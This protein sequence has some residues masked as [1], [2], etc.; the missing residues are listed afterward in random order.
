M[1]NEKLSLRKLAEECNISY[2]T[3]SR[4]MNGQGHKHKLATVKLVESTA[5]KLGYRRNLLA[6]GMM[7]GQSLAIGVV[8][9]Y[10]SSREFNSE[11]LEGIQ[12]E[13]EQH[14]YVAINLTVNGSKEDVARAHQLIERRVDG[15]IYR[16][17]PFG[18]SD[19]YINEL[20]RH[21]IPLV[22]IIDN[23]NIVS[24][25]I[26]FVGVDEKSL[27]IQAAEY[28]IENGH[29][30]VAFT[31]IG[32]SRFDHPLQERFKSFK[33]RITEEGGSV[34]TTPLSESPEANSQEIRKILQMK[35]DRPSAIFCSV[36]DI[37]YTTYGIAQK[38]EL[39]IPHDLSIL[40]SCDY[41]ASRYFLP[42]LTS[43]NL[44]TREIGRQAA[45][46]LIRRIKESKNE[47]SANI[48]IRPNLIKRDSV[49]NLTDS[50][51]V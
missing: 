42:A 13:L 25:N 49:Y 17:H 39:S 30:Q 3:V 48:T 22:S 27:G 41:N 24:N 50:V 12:I 23:D 32:N 11:I 5:K 34:I 36:D 46:L 45:D 51:R 16:S 2:Q 14:D 20:K 29:K 8:L 37:A 33:S 38:L 26:D 35:K 21:R 43:F 6:R 47:G 7:T 28:L 44:N 10:Y 4:I 31:R 40:G 15:V 18:E 19:L 1:K 9:P